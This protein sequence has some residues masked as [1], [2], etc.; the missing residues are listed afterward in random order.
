MEPDIHNPLFVIAK[1]RDPQH[2]DAQI[3]A[4]VDEWR[5]KLQPAFVEL[6][7]LAQEA[8]VELD[9]DRSCEAVAAAIGEKLVEDGMEERET[10]QA[11]T[12]IDLVRTLP[13]IR[14][15]IVDVLGG[16]SVDKKAFRALLNDLIAMKG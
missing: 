12:I 15:R 2:D 4:Q 1:E 6:A 10:P 9:H 3:Q 11:I 16:E 8:L 5:R 13:E 7:T 14:H